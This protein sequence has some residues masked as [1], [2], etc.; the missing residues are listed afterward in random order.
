MAIIM[1]DLV[2]KTENVIMASDGHGGGIK[3]PSIFI[4]EREGDII[5]NWTSS[6]PTKSVILSIKFET[7][8]T[9]QVQIGLWLDSYS[10]ASYRFLREFRPFY[11]KVQDKGK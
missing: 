7:N 5:K 4:G 11:E 1:D 2:E 6:N 9:D 3:I 10:R 8:V